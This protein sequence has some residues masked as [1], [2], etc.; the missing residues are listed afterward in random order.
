MWVASG[1]T[2]S[3]VTP[4][5][6]TLY[7][8][9]IV[10]DQS[11]TVKALAIYV[12]TGAA[13]CTARL[14]L[15]TDAPGMPGAQLFD[16]GDLAAATS[17]TVVTGTLGTPLT[18]AAGPYW[19]ACVLHTAASNVI[20]IAPA[21]LISMTTAALSVQNT[22]PGWAVTGVTGALPS[23]WSGGTGTAVAC[24]KITVNIA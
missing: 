8:H 9:R 12:N 3:N 6:N 21:D 16:S 10:F 1:G 13:T 23:P 7:A 15:F 24:P 11:V 4:T 19:L 17:A 18:I 5:L 20:A 2:Q 22:L 14:G